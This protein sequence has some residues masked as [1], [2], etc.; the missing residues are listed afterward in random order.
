[1]FSSVVKTFPT[2]VETFVSVVK[3]LA[4]DVE[5]FAS[6]EII[7]KSVVAK[8]W[9]DVEKFW[10]AELIFPSAVESWPTPVRK[11]FPNALCAQP[12]SIPAVL[13]IAAPAPAH[14]LLP[15]SAP[16]RQPIKWLI[17]LIILFC[18]INY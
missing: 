15:P 5:T 1:M 7:Y 10:T 3:I 4:T 12:V 14:A 16:R 2:D 8:V 6:N 9:S 17:Y 18:Y 13:A 11:E